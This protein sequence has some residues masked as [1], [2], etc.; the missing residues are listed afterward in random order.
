MSIFLF[1][2][3]SSFVLIPLNLLLRSAF[4]HVF[5][6]WFVSHFLLPIG[7]TFGLFSTY[8]LLCFSC[9]TKS[10]FNFE[11]HLYYR[12]CP[13]ITSI[14]QNDD[15]Y[16][17]CFNTH[18]F[19]SALSANKQVRKVT[20]L[21]PIAFVIAISITLVHVPTWYFNTHIFISCLPLLVAASW[22]LNG[23]LTNCSFQ[24]R[25]LLTANQSA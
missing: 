10:N 4:P 8:F 25:D 16:C 24:P 14:K 15:C 17:S 6:F 2:S 21:H 12:I 22:C 7:L 5:M 9:Y 23:I 1:F 19:I 13:C 20:S 11:Y 3:S 18:I